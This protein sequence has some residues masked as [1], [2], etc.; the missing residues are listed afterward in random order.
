MSSCSSDKTENELDCIL[1]EEYIQTLKD[2]EQQA[3]KIAKRQLKSSFSLKHSIGFKKFLAG[4]K[5]T[6]H[7]L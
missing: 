4:K 3:F 7:I 6:K 2:Y 1:E 5:S